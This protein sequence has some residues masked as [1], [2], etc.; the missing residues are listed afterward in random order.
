[1][2]TLDTFY[3]IDKKIGYGALKPSEEKAGLL[4]SQKSGHGYVDLPSL[5]NLNFGLPK[6]QVSGCF[7]LS[8]FERQQLLI[9][10]II[11]RCWKRC[12]VGE[13]LN[14]LLHFQPL[15]EFPCEEFVFLFIFTPD[16]PSTICECSFEPP[17]LWHTKH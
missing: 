9:L 4:Q 5:V 7:L 15:D 10:S 13:Y 14:I 2:L 3:L 17:P 1:M 16:Y 6:V 8:S 11:I 12:F